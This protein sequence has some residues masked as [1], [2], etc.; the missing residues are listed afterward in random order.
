MKIYSKLYYLVLILKFHERILSL[1]ALVRHKEYE[2]E[3][4]Q[5]ALD[6]LLID[7]KNEFKELASSLF[8]NVPQAVIKI[9]KWELF[10]LNFCLD[11]TKAFKQWSGKEEL[12]QNADLQALTILRQLSQNKSSLIHMTH[13][14]NIAYDLAE[15]FR[16]IYKRIE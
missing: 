9:P 7:R 10:V 14:M 6:M 5:K 11:I 15:E 3:R 16:V 1:M 13:L 8:Y 2:D 12:S 4:T